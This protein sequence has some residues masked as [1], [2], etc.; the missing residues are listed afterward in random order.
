[1]TNDDSNIWLLRVGKLRLLEGAHLRHEKGLAD[2]HL[3]KIAIWIHKDCNNG[4]N[5]PH[6]FMPDFEG[7]DEM[8]S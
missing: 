3:V 8:I 1:M 5:L 6:G 7:S 4:H 2:W